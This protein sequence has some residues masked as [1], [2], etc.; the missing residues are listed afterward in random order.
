MAILLPFSKIWS[1]FVTR[2]PSGEI[3]LRAKV[4]R[5]GRSATSV[6][7]RPRG[8]S[9]VHVAQLARAPYYSVTSSRTMFT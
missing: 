9:H 8:H 3:S 2:M 7:T 6:H 4:I 1:I 5:V